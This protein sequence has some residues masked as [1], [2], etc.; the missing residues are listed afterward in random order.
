MGPAIAC[1]KLNTLGGLMKNELRPILDQQLSQLETDTKLLEGTIAEIHRRYSALDDVGSWNLL[2][3]G[4]ITQEEKLRPILDQ[5]MSR[6]EGERELLEGTIAEIHRRYSV[7][8]DVWSW[9]LLAPEEITQENGMDHLSQSEEQ[10]V[11]SSEG[12][13]QEEEPL[14]SS[15]MEET[16][17]LAG[18]AMTRKVRILMKK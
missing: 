10:E 6:L 16:Q 7:L 2:T 18:Y 3:P 8:D 12:T 13:V 9:N 11:E 5:Q 1:E 14:A 17:P 15:L 4:E